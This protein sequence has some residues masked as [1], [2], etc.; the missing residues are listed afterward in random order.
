MRL[1]TSW[2]CEVL[3][4]AVVL[5]C[6]LLSS[7]A[8][9]AESLPVRGSLGFH[10]EWHNPD[11]TVHLR[12]RTYHPGGRRFL[13]RDTYAGQFA[14]TPS[15]NR[16]AFAENNPSTWSDPSGYNTQKQLR[17]AFR[18]AAGLLGF[19]DLPCSE[20]GINSEADKV[21]TT[22]APPRKWHGLGASKRPNQAKSPSRATRAMRSVKR[23]WQGVVKGASGNP[24]SFDAWTTVA[25][26]SG[27]RAIAM[28]REGEF[29]Y[30]GDS[31]TGE[32]S[33]RR[34]IGTMATDDEAVVLLTLR[35]SGGARETIRTTANHP[36]H[37]NGKGFVD[38]GELRAGEDRVTTVG[39]TASVESVRSGGY[40]TMYNLDVEGPDTFFVGSSRALVHNCDR[41]IWSP[42]DSL[43]DT[44]KKIGRIFNTPVV[45]RLE[46]VP[47]HAVL[48]IHSHGTPNGIATG[49]KFND[50]LSARQIES[51]VL[52][53]KGIKTCFLLTCYGGLVAKKTYDDV[54]ETT[55]TRL[56][57]FGP[58]TG[59]ETDPHGWPHS[60]M[61]DANGNNIYRNGQY[62]VR[63]TTFRQVG[64]PGS[65]H[66][67]EVFR[68]LSNYAK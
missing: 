52:G 1:A 7:R 40:A 37:V 21:T 56:N 54:L 12:A 8:D 64:E 57:L 22:I 59:F 13:Q 61:I 44:S 5:S 50:W 17:E 60:Y 42:T 39:G 68:A 32:V 26:P 41:V 34:V 9:A 24:C 23:M 47:Q 11:G 36:F 48:T 31:R 4:V 63:E 25:T 14:A 15:L 16:Y 3:L 29:V 38:A 2:P 27:D 33:P 67:D 65:M 45:T 62:L 46:D 18:C 43:K 28:I 35:D 19:P 58:A 20:I 6:F 10:G 49:D 55:G 53:P 66:I 30:A 51:A